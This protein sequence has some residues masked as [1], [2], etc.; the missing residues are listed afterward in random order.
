MIFYS[1]MLSPDIS[2]IYTLHINET[3]PMLLSQYCWVIF[4][5]LV[6]AQI[7]KNLPILYETLTL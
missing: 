1:S 2:C 7:V 5:K 6:I 3:N 4:E